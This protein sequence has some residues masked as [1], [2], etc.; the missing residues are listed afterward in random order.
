[1]GANDNDG[2]A[3]VVIGDK[4]ELD[5]DQYSALLDRIAELEAAATPAP[6]PKAKGDDVDDLLEE[7]NR[8]KASGGG[9]GGQVDLENMSNTELFQYIMEVG[10]QEIRR[11]DVG[12]ETM[13]LMRDI[14]KVSAKFED[15]DL[16]EEEIR[17]IAMKNPTLSIE[18][19]Y[20]LA[21]AE[22]PTKGDKKKQDGGLPK[23]HT[24]KI[25]NL[26]SR[27][28]IGEKPGSIADSSTRKTGT[29]LSTKSAAEEAWDEI[30][31]KDKA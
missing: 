13:K 21:K 23:T 12:L 20:K 22:N 9:G 28:I 10:G 17:D 29:A 6:G 27:Q 11:I 3:P 4:V 16:Y 15:F 2:A 25:L 18:K 24:E 7:A 5:A 31:G 26:P 8:R 14:D 19:A 1:M 30:M